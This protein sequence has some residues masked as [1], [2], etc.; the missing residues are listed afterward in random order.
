MPVT[1]K[2]PSEVIGKSPGWFTRSGSAILFAVIASI[3]VATYFIKYPDVITA[4]V[5]VTTANLPAGII[6]QQNG[7]IVSLHVSENDE[8]RQNDP[9][10][11]IQSTASYSSVFRLKQYLGTLQHHV[12]NDLLFELG[13]LDSL[14]PL[15][16]SYNGLVAS[17][18]NFHRHLNDPLYEIK[19]DK[20]NVNLEKNEV[21][22][23]R[24]RSRFDASSRSYEISEVQHSRDSMLLREQVL[25]QQD[26]EESEKRFINEQQAIIDL[27]TDIAAQAHD[28]KM[29]ALEKEELI[30]SRRETTKQLRQEVLQ[31]I[32]SLENEVDTWDQRHVLRAPISGK[33]SFF[34]LLTANQYVNAGDELMFVLPEVRG[35]FGYCEANAAGMG[36]VHPNQ[37]VHIRLDNYPYEEFGILEGKV[38]SISQLA[39]E[40][41]YMIKV[42]FPE[43]LITNYGKQI[44][45][46]QEMTG[47]AMILTE[48]LRLIERFFS[49]L[50]SLNGR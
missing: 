14:G 27:K 43:Q 3:L 19:I 10:G 9:V 17:L 26:Y 41:V 8:V 50:R 16:S 32:N 42:S 31:A 39:V 37:K 47:S 1:I 34:K 24:F 35:V 4:K 2:N 21:A 48:E 5:T 12:E 33:V 40:D 45:F 25:A 18:S 49:T 6:A 38:T 13:Q 46:K 7:Y 29:I 11:I 30:S 23:E 15:V 22:S 28:R 20:L 36:K 44:D